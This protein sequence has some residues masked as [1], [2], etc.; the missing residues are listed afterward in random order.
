[1]LAGSI[2]NYLGTAFIK[3]K[4]YI[5]SEIYGRLR[6]PRWRRHRRT[7]CLPSRPASCRAHSKVR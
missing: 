1:M 4:I 7:S 5:F 6:G 3:E 2:G